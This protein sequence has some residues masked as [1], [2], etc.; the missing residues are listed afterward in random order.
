MEAAR[1]SKEE[2]V[3]KIQTDFDFGLMFIVDNGID[4]I[5]KILASRNINLTKPEDIFN[6]LKSRIEKVPE[7]ALEILKDV[8]YNPNMNNYTSGLQNEL[9]YA[10]SE[11]LK[12]QGGSDNRSFLAILPS[13]LS[14][15]SSVMSAINVNKNGGFTDQNGN[16]LNEAQF[17][18]EQKRLAEER[19][20]EE[21]RQKRNAIIGGVIFTAVV[22]GIVAVVIVRSNKKNKQNGKS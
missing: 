5:R 21:A 2:I 9:D 6:F 12:E 8:R 20:A 19:A 7:D 1:M 16:P 22:I 10:K 13:I 14:A 17:L 15:A 18:A 4:E 11:N 3:K